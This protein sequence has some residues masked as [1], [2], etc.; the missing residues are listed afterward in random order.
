MIF[1]PPYLYE[2]NSFMVGCSSTPGKKRLGD[3]KFNRHDI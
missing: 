2:V 3:V 1:F